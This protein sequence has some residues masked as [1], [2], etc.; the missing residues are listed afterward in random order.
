MKETFIKWRI[1]FS[2]TTPIFYFCLLTILGLMWQGYNPITTSMSEIGAIDSPFKII[3]N[4]FGFS[5]LG[6]SII[7]F[8]HE[9]QTY[10][11]N[12]IVIR[13]ASVLLLLGGMSMFLVGFLPCDSKCVDATLTGKLHSLTST[14]AALLI[15]TAAMLS[16]K[17]ISKKWNNS[18]GYLTFSLGFFSMMAGPIMFVESFQKYMGLVQRLGIG[19]SLVWIVII[20]TKILVN[21]K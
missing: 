3:M 8:G 12:N 14:I 9:F 16:A 7:F 5:L 6:V 21:R 10:F 17:S 1:I 20:S 18:W 19:F 4:Y 15:P 2:L 13:I 11:E